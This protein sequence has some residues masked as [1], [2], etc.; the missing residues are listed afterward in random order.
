MKASN[1]A[2]SDKITDKGGAGDASWERVSGFIW[3]WEK[4]RAMYIN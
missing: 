2:I 4:G 3:I 1:I